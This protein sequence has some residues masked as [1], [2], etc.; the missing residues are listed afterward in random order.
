MTDRPL[1]LLSIATLYPAPQRPGFGRFVKRQMD[2]L[3]A[4]GDWEV[5]VIN[6]VGLPPLH[7]GRYASLAEIPPVETDGPITVYHEQFTLIPRISG[8]FNPALIAR[9]IL[10]LARRLHAERP[11]DAVDAQ[12][13]YPDGPA[14]ARIAQDLGLPFAIKAR[15]SDIHFWGKTP[16]ALE[17]MHAAAAQ[18][19]LLLAVS[20]AL[21]RDMAALG[22][23]DDRTVVHYTGLDRERFQPLER[24][25]AR[26]LVAAMPDLNVW[27]KGR[28][29][30]SVGALVPVKGQD[31]V[32]RAMPLLPEDVHL[33]I[34]GSGPEQARLETL[35]AAMG[36]AD[37][38]Q[39]LGAVGHET[40]PG[41]LSAADVMVLPSEREG[42]ANAWIE[43]LACGTPI[44]VPD[45]G[46]ASE[47]VTSPAAGR[48]VTR[49]PEAIATAVGELL[50]APPPQDEVAQTVAR[51]SW[52]ANA[53]DMADR[54]AVMVRRG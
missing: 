54:Y 14:A 28:L 7:F 43:A 2:A 9:A 8:R 36:A 42:L 20:D 25:A 24:A 1:R 50:A 16:Y 34:A 51:F 52:E 40:L 49:D 53:A 37:R 32:I 18:A 41:L 45:I 39:F 3:A 19:D 30:L 38:V 17:Q 46:G 11:F 33:A 27:S 13:F 4:R 35:A 12:F 6:P 44:V 29:L 47:I 5:T 21:R 15:G 22:L 31:L 48:L 26:Q 10:P 23:P